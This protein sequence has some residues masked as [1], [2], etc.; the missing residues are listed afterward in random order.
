[1]K[2]ISDH[3]GYSSVTAVVNHLLALERKGAIARPR[4]ARTMT[5]SPEYAQRMGIADAG[6]E[7]MKIPIVG[8]V[9]AGEPILAVEDIE[10][11]F[12]LDQRLVRYGNTFM[13]RVKGE[14]MINA[15]IQPGD[16]VLVQPQ[17]NA[18]HNDIVVAILNDEATVKRYRIYADYIELKPENDALQPMR[19]P[20]RNCPVTIV[21]KVIG[22]FRRF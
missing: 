17:Q 18:D 6:K 22:V 21:G 20:R 3:F 8:K 9:A 12:I 2:E 13:L 16:L 4:G 11:Y 14:S 15:H 10:D 1:M 19:Y 5:I 7:G